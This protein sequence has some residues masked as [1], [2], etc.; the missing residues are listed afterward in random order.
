MFDN[1]GHDDDAC[2][3]GESLQISALLGF[4]AFLSPEIGEARA[5]RGTIDASVE[6][7]ER[8]FYGKRS[9]M[10]VNGAPI[11]ARSTQSGSAPPKLRAK[12]LIAELNLINRQ[13]HRI[14]FQV[15]RAVTRLGTS[16]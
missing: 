7:V 3:V 11:S 9:D 16:G 2:T 8:T 10:V 14:M 12:D 6:A 4:A 13:I 5:A 15:D 1:I